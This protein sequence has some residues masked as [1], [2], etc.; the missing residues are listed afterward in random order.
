MMC[1]SE[2]E[3]AAGKPELMAARRLSQNRARTLVPSSR[4]WNSS[5]RTVTR[6]AM[7]S[8]TASSSLIMLGVPFAMLRSSQ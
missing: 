7:N 1:S 2:P 5:T 4:S 8:T 6:A 3:P